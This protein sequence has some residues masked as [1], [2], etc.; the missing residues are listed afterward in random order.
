MEQMHDPTLA[1]DRIRQDVSR[2]P[3]GDSRLFLN[4]C[5][6]C[7][8][9]M[10]PMAQAFAYYNY[11]D[12]EEDQPGAIEYT[13]GSVQPKYFNND[14]NFPQGYRTPDDR[15]T[16]YWR[17]GQNSYLGFDPG[18]PGEG[19]GAKTLGEELGNSYAFAQCQVK[20]VFKAVCLRD[21][22]DAADRGAVDQIVNSFRTTGY[23]MKRVFADTALHCMG[24]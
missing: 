17:T 15:W 22:Q 20:K 18:L 24:Q 23:S 1:P 21:P 7:H 4:N 13:P 6:G 14:L 3:G 10:D 5:V 16:N 8:T 19:Y 2:S 12:V 9:G 11:P